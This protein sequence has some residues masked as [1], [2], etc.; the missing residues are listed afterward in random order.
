MLLWF[1]GEGGGGGGQ[2]GT[3]VM[4]LWAE[5]GTSE[6]EAEY[7]LGTVQRVREDGFFTGG[8]RGEEAQ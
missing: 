5:E 4:A 2:E 6:A 8:G 3:R 7:F 1:W